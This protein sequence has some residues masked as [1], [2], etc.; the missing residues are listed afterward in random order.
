MIPTDFTSGFWDIFITV[1]SIGG[2]LF[3]AWLLF[4]GSRL[5][6]TE[7][8]VWD[9]D[10]TEKNHSAPL[11]WVL[12]FVGVIVFAA[13]Y[14]FLYP[15]LGT[16]YAGFLDWSSEKQFQEE[17][18]AQADRFEAMFKEYRQMD[19]PTIAKDNDAMQTASRLFYASCAQCHGTDAK[20]RPGYPDLTDQDWLH[21]GSPQDILTSITDGRKGEMLSYVKELGTEGVLQ[22]V[23]TVK[24]L[25]GLAYDPIYAARGQVHFQQICA[26]CH[27]AEGKGN[28]AL[29][30]PNLTDDIWLYG[31]SEADLIE[32]V[33][34]GRQALMPAQ[35]PLLGDLKVRLLAAYVWRFSNMSN[36]D[37]AETK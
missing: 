19:I 24:S 32:T 5:D 35:K 4:G 3:C 6:Q 18:L 8:P 17:K 27:G 36:L 29:G 2:V 33:T 16:Q 12:L 14:F 13:I 22:V 30:A 25:S 15:A 23:H 34:N 31:N 1:F 26:A 20:G 37:A 10:L 11:W 28:T 7:F 9:H 21:G